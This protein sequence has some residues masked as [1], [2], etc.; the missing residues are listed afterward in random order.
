MCSIADSAKPN[1]CCKLDIIFPFLSKEALEPIITF[2]Y[3]GKIFCEEQN[4]ASS[5]LKN[6]TKVLGFPEVIGKSNFYFKTSSLD[7]N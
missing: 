6:L 2:L 1:C 7:G 4:D 3:S 5:I